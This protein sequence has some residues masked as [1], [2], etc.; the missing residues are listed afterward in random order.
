MNAWGAHHK[1]VHMLNPIKE[2]ITDNGIKVRCLVRLGTSFQEIGETQKSIE[3]LKKSWKIAEE[4]NDEE[5]KA[6]I[7]SVLG[8]CY[9][10]LGQIDKAIEYFE[11]S[12]GVFK[13][14]NEAFAEGVNNTDLGI[15]YL[16]LGQTD[17]AIEYFEQSIPKLK[18]VNIHRHLQKVF[19]YL[20]LAYMFKKNI[21]KHT[22][23]LLNPQN[24]IIIYSIIVF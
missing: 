4:Q 7:Q 5:W 20:A 13:D 12:I 10:D 8:R 1:V 16:D 11:Q 18:E 21:L 19:Y 23:R 6:T 22:L 17:K 2:K 9:M 3:V 24:M 14:E 15:G